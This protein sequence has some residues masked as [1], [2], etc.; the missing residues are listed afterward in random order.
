MQANE[1]RLRPFTKTAFSLIINI[2]TQLAFAFESFRSKFFHR[3]TSVAVGL[4]A[5]RPLMH[6]AANFA[7]H[8]LGPLS[9]QPL[10][11]DFQL[12]AGQLNQIKIS[13]GTINQGYSK[14]TGALVCSSPPGDRTSYAFD[15]AER[16]KLRIWFGDQDQLIDE[17]VFDGFC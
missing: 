16:P 11:Q 4:L 2:F 12:I 7:C 17:Y 3:L 1:Y 15:E 8:L 10:P 9:F 13:I 6:F 14:T 5:S